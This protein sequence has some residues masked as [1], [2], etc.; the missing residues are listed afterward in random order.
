M[1]K[2]GNPGQSAEPVTAMQVFHA[3][4]CP[5]SLGGYKHQFVRTSLKKGRRCTCRQK[6]SSEGRKRQGSC[7]LSGGRFRSSSLAVR[8]QVWSE[9]SL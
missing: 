6:D 3:G 4:V 2:N 5:W 1:E 8:A 9:L 7:H